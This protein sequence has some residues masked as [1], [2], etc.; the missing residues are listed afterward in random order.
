MKYMLLIA[1]DPTHLSG[2]EGQKRIPDLIARHRALGAELAASGLDWSGSQLQPASTA[3]TVRTDGDK[4]S[5]H[6]GPYAETREQL[7]G[8]YMIDVPDLDAALAWAKKIPMAGQGSV[9][10]RPL[11]GM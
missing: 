1:H 4:Q 3:T 11:I 6:D 9:E 10:V 7:A 8:Y 2:E 5:L